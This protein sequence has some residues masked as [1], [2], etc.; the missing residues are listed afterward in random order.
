MIN[1]SQS[2]TSVLRW[3]IMGAFFQLLFLV[4]SLMLLYF[5]FRREAMWCNLVFLLANTLIT[6]VN[7]YL[8]Q[9]PAYGA[10]Y[11]FS[12]LAAALLAWYFLKARTRKLIYYTFMTQKMPKEI[13]E[14]PEFIVR[15]LG[16]TVFTADHEKHGQAP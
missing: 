14:Q 13:N 12:T 7:V 11:F 9:V 10:G 16:S 15:S 4:F 1:Y 6:A 8:R 3:G 5:E 2:F